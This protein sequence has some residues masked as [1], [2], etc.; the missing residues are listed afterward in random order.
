MYAKWSEKHYVDQ[1]CFKLW[2]QNNDF[3]S[4][5]GKV[6]H[7]ISGSIL[8]TLKSLNLFVSK[9]LILPL[10]FIIILVHL[11][12]EMPS[13]KN[14]TFSHQQ[15]IWIVTNYGEFKI[16]TA[17]SKHFKLLLRQLL[18]SYAFSRVINRFMASSDVYP[19]RL[20]DP[21]R[22]KNIEEN[23][24]TTLPFLFQLLSRASEH[25]GKTCC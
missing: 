24:D 20:P 14:Q 12:F 23:I 15:N 17:M 3:T 5:C 6:T 25:R 9:L 11:I 13:R 18:H 10:L 2:H 7:Y 8:Y 1:L 4:N 21:P 19:S 16:P 22:T